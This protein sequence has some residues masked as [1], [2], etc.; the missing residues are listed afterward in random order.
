MFNDFSSNSRARVLSPVLRVVFISLL[1]LAATPVPAGAQVDASGSVLKVAPEIREKIRTGG[2]QRLV[3]RMTEQ[4][5]LSG[6]ALLTSKI[7]KGR[8]VYQ[9]VREVADR[10]Q[11]AV[12]RKLVQMGMSCTPFY[13]ANI[14]IADAAPGT[15]I[16]S[17]AIEK[18]AARPDIARI[19]SDE[20]VTIDDLKEISPTMAPPTGPVWNILWI[21]APEVWNTGFRGQGIVYANIDT[22]VRWTHEALKGNYRG[23]NGSTA[24]HNYNWWDASEERSAAP[25]DTH[26]HGTHTMGPA[27][28]DK[29]IGVAPGAQWIACRVAFG[30]KTSVA[31]ILECLEFMLAPWDLNHNNPNPDEAPDVIGHSYGG[32]TRLTEIATWR[33]VFDNLDAAGVFNAAA[34]GNDGACSKA[35]GFPQGFSSVISVGALGFETTQIAPFS[36]RGPGPGGVAGGAAIRPSITA[37]GTGIT[38]SKANSDNHYG[39]FSGTSMAAPLLAGAVVVTLSKH[40]E[41]IGQPAAIRKLIM[42]TALPQSTT[43][44]GGGPVPNNVYGYGEL[45]LLELAR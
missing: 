34:A 18:L 3:I 45:D 13:V 11:P 1:A 25:V 26:G 44:C 15:S 35:N 16:G 22:G 33:T 23:W 37:P 14:V 28:G 27:V 21:H 29:G 10:T 6:A 36:S 20:Q 19:S 32:V 7:D 42:E 31:D 12:C 8:F 40:P 38:S 4:A 41:L 9:A 5:D 30:T 24:N 43:E 2:P 39:R 17:D